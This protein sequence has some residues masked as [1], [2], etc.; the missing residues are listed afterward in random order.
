[1]IDLHPKPDSSHKCPFCDIPL[2]VNGWYIPGLRCLADLSCSKCK[3]EFF[4]DLLVGHALYYPQLLE[5][6]TGIVHD[7]YKI[8]WF[9]NQLSESFLK[10][11]SKEL[12]F[13]EEIIKQIK[14]PILL[15]CLDFLYGHSLLKLLNAQ[16]Y[17]DHTPDYDLI[18]LIPNFMR[19]LVPDG[20][21]AIWTVDFPLITGGQWNEWLARKIQ[22]KLEKYYKVK[23]SV[24]Y[25]HPHPDFYDIQRFS[26]V[27]SFELGNWFQKNKSINIT[28]IWREDRLWNVNKFWYKLLR[29][30][31]KLIGLQKFQKI[32]LY[33][34]KNK[35]IRIAKKVNNLHD[36]VQF[37]V[38]GLGKFGV[39]PSWINDFRAVQ[40][41][42]L[43]EKKWCELYSKSHIVI[44]VHGSNMLL[45]SAHAGS[46][47]A[48]IP[49]DRW[50][51]IIQDFLVKPYDPRKALLL[52]RCLPI[53]VQDNELVEVISNILTN[54]FNEQTM[55]KNFTSH[56]IPK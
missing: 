1:M 32:L 31:F 33:E 27:P 26:G 56:N 9:S 20:V 47:I 16:Y 15:N 30:L 53:S 39:F 38:V 51:N 24:A 36:D 14:N 48:L 50:G 41:D 46:T 55:S 6:N 54:G 5:K 7:P 44:G 29:K 22:T 21:A 34:Q 28:F 2:D 43:T 42:S 12:D 17:I 35:M 45:P 18:V 8:N 37:S 13:K 49:I 52:Y 3:K 10:R 25:S 23:I 11:N 40:V 4:G 19:W